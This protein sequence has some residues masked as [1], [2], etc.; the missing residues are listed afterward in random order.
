MS[1]A[2]I[3]AGTI[4]VGV[5]GSQQAL[6]ALD[7]AVEQAAAERRAI[8]LAHAVTPLDGVWLQP[9]VLDST[10]HVTG[11]PSGSQAIL[12][13]ARGHAA[14]R[15]PGV[16]VTEVLRVQDPRDLLLELGREAAM[17]VLGSRGR[18]PV[19]SLLLGS[20]GVALTRRAPCPVVVHRPHEE[21]ERHGVLVG[22]DASERSLPVLEFGYRV[23]AQRGLPLRV[24]L[25]HW[26]RP[27]DPTGSAVIATP[28]PSLEDER[29]ALAEAVAGLGEKYPEVRAH[30]E[31]VRGLARAVL[32]LQTERSD[33]MVLGSHHGG[34]P[35]ELMFG[36]ITTDVLEHASCPVAVVPVG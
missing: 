24:V 32:A 4:V 23:A 12:D 9:E 6:D 8:T 1:D 30:T 3:P 2:E 17:V 29:L 25:C 11:V 16:E 7:W 18:G 21:S 27:V 5:D 10:L 14:K 19:R 26:D 35:T 13:Q 33:L 34:L 28:V 31:V 22:V 20:V 15:A 36:S